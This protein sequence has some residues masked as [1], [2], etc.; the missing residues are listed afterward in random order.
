MLN[1]ITFTLGLLGIL[2][3]CSFT[4][5]QGPTG[6]AEIYVNGDIQLLSQ[7]PDA[8]LETSGIAQRD[9]LIWTLNDSGDG[10]VLYALNS[11]YK[12]QRKV[13]FSEAKNVDWEELAQDEEFLYIADCGN[14]RANRVQLQIYK[15]RWSELLAAEEKVAADT[16]TFEYAD[17]T[18]FSSS[19]NHNYDCEALASVGN[20]LWLFTKNRKDEKTNLYRLDKNRAFQQVYP[21]DSFD[22]RGLITAADYDLNSKSLVLLGYEK[23][24]IFGSSFVWV[25]P[26]KRDGE[27]KPIWEDAR[28]Q[29]LSPY[30][31]WEAILWDRDSASGKLILTTEKS[32]L[33]DVS[34]G[35]LEVSISK[36]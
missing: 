25:I 30:A 32:P 19:K 4:K 18:D 9:G 5:V 8:V 11:E 12:L 22:V 13:S 16:I 27:I 15:V 35:E 29:K 26:T 28:Y 10:P 21:S 17:R 33:L 31:Q 2:S 1:K 14:N 36:P 24:I 20:E 23:N 3:G 7:L 6:Q 34:I